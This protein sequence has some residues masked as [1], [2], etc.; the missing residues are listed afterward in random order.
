MGVKKNVVK[1]DTTQKDYKDCLFND[2]DH[3][4]TMIVIR[5]HGHEIYTEE[6]NKV[7]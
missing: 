4:R 2:K 3:L 6:V 7:A 1:K 5:S